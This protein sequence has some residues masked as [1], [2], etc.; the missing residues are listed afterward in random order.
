M[1]ATVAV[2]GAAETT[3]IG[4]LPD[5]SQIELHAD[6]ALNALADC[7][8]TPA[9]VDGLASVGDSPE[10]IADYLGIRPAWVDGTLIGGCSALAHLRHAVAALETGLCNVVLLTHGQS[11][12]S[13][14]GR[15]RPSV[16]DDSLNGQFEEVFGPMGPPSLLSIPLVRYMHHWGLTHEQLATVP[17]VQREWAQR[18][19]RALLKEPLSV[20]D[21]LASKPVS[22]PLNLAHC[23][24]VTDGG[25]ALV[26]T[27]ADRARDFPK[28]P[29][30]VLGSGEGYGSPMVS[31]MDDYTSSSAFVASGRAA[32]RSAGIARGDVDHLMLYDP[33]AH[34]PLFALGDLG[35]VPH[36]EVGRFVAD[37]NTA[38]GGSLPVNTNGGGLS[39]THTGM[40]G[41]FA[42][43]ESIRQLRGEAA[44]QVEGVEVAVTHGIG[45]MFAAAAT[46]VFATASGS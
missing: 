11:G 10:V 30:Y 1:K 15:T 4:V 32:F 27:R 45:G 42:L 37:R 35:F 25:G 18:N 39:Y 43:Q 28:K 29:V 36:G 17:V 33:F 23:C 31:Q 16:R 13:L 44:A 14:I 38:P 22:Y 7:G 9:D 12:R 46:L 40:Y 19:P 5:M 34:V 20:A 21:V 41:M 26:L 8:L 3:R 24:V 2:V 6:A